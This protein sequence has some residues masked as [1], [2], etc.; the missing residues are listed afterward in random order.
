[1][2]YYIFSRFKLPLLYQNVKQVVDKQLEKELAGVD[3]VAFTSDCWTSRSNDPYISLTL[4]YI[5]E[6]FDLRR[7][8]QFI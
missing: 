3:L 6:E 1:M 2:N 5:T 7:Y 8:W 4:H